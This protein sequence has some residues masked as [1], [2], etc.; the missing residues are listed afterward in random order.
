MKHALLF[1]AVVAVSALCFSGCGESRTSDYPDHSVNTTRKV[2]DIKLNARDQKDAADA[3]DDAVNTKLDFRERQIREQAKAD[4]ATFALNSDKEATDRDAKTRELTLQAKHDKDVV[5]AD[6]ADKLKTSPAE[7]SVE[8]Q[9]EATTKKSEID[10][11]LTKKLAPLLVDS[12]QSK[13]KTLQRNME[14]DLDEAKA[15]SALTKERSVARDQ[16]REK[17][18]AIDRWTTDE[19]AKVAKEAASSK[20]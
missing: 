15:I 17:K 14:L 7:Q 12:E 9:A 4:R 3:T 10:T 1:S 8:L 6:L 11:K 2:D 16:L 5:D 18:I 13:S 20:K 19:L